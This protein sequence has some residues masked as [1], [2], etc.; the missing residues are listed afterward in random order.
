M[1]LYKIDA[2][3]LSPRTAFFA[4]SSFR[5]EDVTFSGADEMQIR[6]FQAFTVFKIDGAD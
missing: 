2:T 4:L 1:V 5:G 6:A 3:L